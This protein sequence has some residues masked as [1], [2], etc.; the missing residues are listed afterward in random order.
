MKKIMT[1]IIKP[2]LIAINLIIVRKHYFICLLFSLFSLILYSQKNFN[3]KI[4]NLTIGI[5]N[6]DCD[7]NDSVCFSHP[8]GQYS[9]R[10]EKRAFYHVEFDSLTL[11]WEPCNLTD[12]NIKSIKRI[13]IMRPSTNISKIDFR[14][15]TSLKTIILVGCDEDYLNSIPESILNHKTLK[16]IILKRVGLTKSAYFKI[17]QTKIN[18]KGTKPCDNVPHEWDCKDSN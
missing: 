17:K 1:Y 14:V 6:H 8:R 18:F 13:T 4:R 15:F 10:F 5:L 3:K 11:K 16:R 7:F 12:K 9:K 2:K